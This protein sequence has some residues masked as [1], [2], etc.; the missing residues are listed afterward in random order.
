MNSSTYLFPIAGILTMLAALAVWEPLRREP[1]FG[2]KS[3]SLLLAVA[4]VLGVYGMIALEPVVAGGIAFRLSAGV[5]TCTLMVMVI[6]LLGILR[7]EVQG[8]GLFLLPVISLILLI[9]PL[10]PESE[11]VLIHTRSALETGHILIAMIAYA[12]LTLAAIHALMHMQLNR[13]LKRKQLNRLMQYLPSL[14]DIEVH[15]FAQVRW[16]VWLLGIGI[17]FGLSWQWETM[18]HVELLHHKMLLAFIAWGVLLWLVASHRGGKIRGNQ[19]S[20]MVLTAYVLLLLAYFG[21]KL[22]QTWLQ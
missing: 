20:R 5:A 14:V 2:P 22:V 16:V 12:L 15:M 8:L 4:I 13:A 19:A 6:Y 3:I 17:A 11:A 7:H 18:G 21:V 10:L 9:I 1:H